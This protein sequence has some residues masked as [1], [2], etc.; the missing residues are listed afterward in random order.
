MC[1]WAC[2]NTLLKQK[3]NQNFCQKIQCRF[4]RTIW[5]TAKYHGWN[6]LIWSVSFA[7]QTYRDI[8]SPHKKPERKDFPGPIFQR[9]IEEGTE[10]KEKTDV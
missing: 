9:S 8:T 4:Q 7:R 1:D 3:M 5:R 2:D 10:S 6:I